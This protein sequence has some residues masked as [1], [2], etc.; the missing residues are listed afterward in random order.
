MS[1]LAALALSVHL[2]QV[3][4]IA[5]SKNDA[6]LVNISGRQR[7]LL[8]QIYELSGEL[9]RTSD[10]VI[11]ERLHKVLGDSVGRMEKSHNTLVYGN[12]SMGI[13]K[14]MDAEIRPYYFGPD[15][16]LDRQTREFIRH[17]RNLLNDAKSPH[18]PDN[19]DIRYI[20]REASGDLKSSFDH[21]VSRYQKESKIHLENLHS[22]E[23][24]VLL[25][26]L[27]VL[28][29]SAFMVFRPMIKRVKYEFDHHQK[30]IESLNRANA[31]L[32]ERAIKLASANEMLSDFAHVV[33]HDLKAPLRA[34]HNYSDFL[35]ED[36]EGTLDEEQQS[37]LSGMI[38]AVAEANRL[39][40]DMLDYSRVLSRDLPYEMIDV[41]K[42]IEG[43]V[44][45]VSMPDEVKF[46]DMC[47]GECRMI[48][49][50]SP[51]L[52]RQIVQN[53]ISNAV[54]YNNSEVKQISVG[55]RI[56]EGNI[57]E[58][59]VRDN[60]IGIDP[61][62][63]NKIFNIFQRLHTKGQFNGTGIGLAIVKKAVDRIGGTIRVESEPGNGSTF[64]VSLPVVQL[65]E[66][67]V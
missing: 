6:A 64:F 49:E 25:I 42:F 22:V 56:V 48:V 16:F 29:L 24:Y 18:D 8:Q 5:K 15:G 9:G 34:V 62:Y 58:I 46:L 43:E 4:I 17:V 37:Y 12:P 27:L 57:G 39:I 35:R 40:D 66:T 50:T 23:L 47:P 13:D 7:M 2:I 54:K 3:R 1:T 26:T 60:G 19:P 55:C 44:K 45:A 65:K 31:A 63:F 21:V 10:P 67:R 11:V 51:V 33:S 20:T 59:F 32:S 38:K 14:P 41:G 36:L 53:L 28:A 30:A 52:L 61:K